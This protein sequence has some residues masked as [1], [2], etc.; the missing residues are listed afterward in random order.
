[1]AE[2]EREKRGR[3]LLLT[4]LVVG[5]VGSLAGIGT[6]SAFSSTT[7]NDG[8]TFA[9]GTVYIHDNDLGAAMYNVS[10]AKPFDTT[11]ACITVTYDGTLPAVVKLYGSAIADPL[12]QYVDL[13]VEEGS[14]SAGFNNCAGFTASGTVYS[15]TLD[16]M[17]NDFAS[18]LAT[19]GGANWTTGTS[20]DYRFTLTL[21]DDNNANGGASG[22]LSVGAHS[23]YWEA[24]NA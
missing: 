15:G 13:T 4:L 3:K 1:M 19:N 24:Q 21:Q 10:N 16:G 14:G 20:V 23:F 2:R 12:A 9:A 8:N 7:S 22:P 17:P 18:G 5:V 6:F 11:T